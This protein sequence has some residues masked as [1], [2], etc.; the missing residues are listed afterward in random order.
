M[1]MF[2]L[3]FY[4]YSLMFVSS[5]YL[6]LSMRSILSVV[7]VLLAITLTGVVKVSLSSRGLVSLAPSTPQYIYH[8]HHYSLPSPSL[9][10]L[11]SFITI[12]I[13]IIIIFIIIPPPSSSSS[14]IIP[15]LNHYYHLHH[16]HLNYLYSHY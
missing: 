16:L 10:S 6:M 11:L 15:S 9:P 5:K 1:G 8:L 13:F 3:I 4:P 14:F 12:I 7:I 2:S